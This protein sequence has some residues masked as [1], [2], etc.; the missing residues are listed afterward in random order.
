MRATKTAILACSL[1]AYSQTDEK[2]FPQDRNLAKKRKINTKASRLHHTNWCHVIWA[3]SGK[4]NKNGKNVTF[5]RLKLCMLLH[6]KTFEAL[7]IANACT[8]LEIFFNCHA[9]EW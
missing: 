7:W 6:G 2:L 3:Q 4:R 1:H 5:F 8:E 9:A